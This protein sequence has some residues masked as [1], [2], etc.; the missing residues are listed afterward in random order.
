MVQALGNNENASQFRVLF[1]FL[2]KLAHIHYF[3]FLHNYLANEAK[4]SHFQDLKCI[5]PL[6]P[7]HLVPGRMST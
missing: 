3:I 2:K 1:D 5:W 4:F 6:E 7:E